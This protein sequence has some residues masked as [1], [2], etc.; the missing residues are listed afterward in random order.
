MSTEWF[1]TTRTELLAH[2]P[3]RESEYFKRFAA[4]ALTRE[5]RVV[6]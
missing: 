5:Q 1:E 4:G 2:N 6:P 3:F